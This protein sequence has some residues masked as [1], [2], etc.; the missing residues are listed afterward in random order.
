MSTEDKELLNFYY[1]MVAYQF[2]HRSA[3]GRIGI[4]SNSGVLTFL[5]VPSSYSF[6]AKIS[7]EPYRKNH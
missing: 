5:F 2:P 7:S 1:I 3:I 4:I 6:E